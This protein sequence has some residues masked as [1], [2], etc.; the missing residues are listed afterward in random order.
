LYKV[1]VY[2]KVEI[3]EYPAGIFCRRFIGNGDLPGIQVH[4][5]VE[6]GE[7]PTAFAIETGDEETGDFGP[8][9]VLQLYTKLI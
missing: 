1:A 8:E 5:E 6:T 9:F 2:L 7:V 3:L 4:I